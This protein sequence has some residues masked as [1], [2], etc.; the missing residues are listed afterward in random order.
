MN[1]DFTAGLYGI[2]NELDALLE[3]SSDVDVLE[4]SYRDHFILKIT[5]LLNLEV[6]NI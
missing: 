1:E 6:R 3:V 4:I 2:A 5:V